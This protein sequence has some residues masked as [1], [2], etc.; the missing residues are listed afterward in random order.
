MKNEEKL[1]I[2]ADELAEMLGISKAHAFK[3]IHTMNEELQT[4]GYLVIPGKVS[5]C[6]FETRWYGQST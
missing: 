4:N 3:L 1:Y 2:T 6:Y 5:R